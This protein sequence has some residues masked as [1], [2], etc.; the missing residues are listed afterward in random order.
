MIR[1][2]IGSKVRDFQNQS[3]VGLFFWLLLLYVVCNM[4][5]WV[6]LGT[7]PCA[8]LCHGFS[9]PEVDQFLIIQMSVCMY[10]KL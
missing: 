4:Y 2:W 7:C 3:G 5:R 6:L 1:V 8:I 9:V 10:I